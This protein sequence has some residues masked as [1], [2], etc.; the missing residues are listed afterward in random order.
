MSVDGLADRAHVH[1]RGDER[2]DERTA[3]GVAGPVATSAGSSTRPPGRTLSCSTCD[4]GARSCAGRRA[5]PSRARRRR[6]SGP[7]GD[8]AVVL[9]PDLDPVLQTALADPL[10][11]EP[12]LLG[13]DGD[14][15]DLRAEVLRGVQAQR[16]PAAADVEEP[17]PGLPARA[18][19]RPARACRAARP[20]RCT[21]GRRSASSRRSRPCAGRGSARRTRWRG[22]SGGGS[23]RGRGRGCAA[24]R[25][26]TAWLAGAGGG[27]PRA[28]RSLA[29]PQQ[30]SPKAPASAVR[31][32]S[33]R[34]RGDP[35]HVGERRVEVALDVQL[36]GDVGLRGA[37]LARMPEQPAQRLRRAQHDRRRVDRPGRAAV[38][39]A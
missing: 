3:A 17:H 34:S 4:V 12:L 24:G 23:P 32:A 10:V 30:R 26:S 5:R 27:G 31:R 2:L 15:G 20:R 33:P 21:P 36:A 1:V 9:Q 22:R 7:S 19:G 16:A 29:Q 14:A 28:P 35:P 8:L 18:C 25:V 38:P 11:D 39:R 37:E 6:R 13:G